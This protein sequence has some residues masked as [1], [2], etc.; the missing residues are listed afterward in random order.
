MDRTDKVVL[1]TGASA[2]IGREAVRRLAAR[3]DTVVAVARSRDRLEAL[4]SEGP[5]RGTIDFVVADVADGP[6]MEAMASAVLAAHGVPDVVV[7]NA[8][9]G[10]DARFESAD[11]SLWRRVLEVNVL[12]VVRTV[13][14]FVPGM[15]AR[16]SGRI[17][18]VS[19][20]VGKR[21]T[22]SYAAYSASKFALH[23]MADALR[24]ELCGSGVTVGLV[25]PSSTETEFDANKLRAGPSQPKIRVAR[26]SADSVARAVV[27]MADSRRR[28]IVLSAE[29][30]ALVVVD[31]I[32]P[33]LVDRLLGR[34][35]RSRGNPVT[36]GGEGPEGGTP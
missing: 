31:A 15:V 22:P 32:A 9:I 2:G 14:P 4:A 26:H 30:K 24:A 27:R 13:R 28:E 33:G 17:V 18:I 1:V 3:G 19:S 34:I 8:G 5:G 25:C 16:G 23:G 36:P 12:G 6:S 10:V 35:L 29:G 20:I 21:G 7:A 11:D